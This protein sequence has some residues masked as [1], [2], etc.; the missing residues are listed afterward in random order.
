M[1]PV[2]IGSQLVGALRRGEGDGEVQT[3]R[4][5]EIPNKGERGCP[6]EAKECCR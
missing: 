2:E 1:T 3:G 4:T 6:I 5:E